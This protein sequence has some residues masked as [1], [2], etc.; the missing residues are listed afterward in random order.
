LLGRRHFESLTKNE[1]VVFQMQVGALVNHCIL[2]ERLWQRGLVAKETREAATDVLARVLPTEG[3]RKYWEIDAQASVEAPALMREIE[4]RSC[5][6]WDELFPW[7]R[8]DGES[9]PSG[10]DARS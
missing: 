6:P 10:E 1:Q 2:A 7:W 3:G 8:E 4:A 5:K 9:E